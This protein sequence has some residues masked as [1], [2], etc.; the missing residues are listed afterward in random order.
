MSIH[1]SGEQCVPSGLVFRAYCFPR[2]VFPEAARNVRVPPSFSRVHT[3]VNR[4][5]LRLTTTM[6]DALPW[7]GVLSRRGKGQREGGEE[8]CSME[9]IINE[10]NDQTI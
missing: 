9:A 4:G 6:T 8:E 1:A 2:S 7:Q 5:A 10:A 3:L